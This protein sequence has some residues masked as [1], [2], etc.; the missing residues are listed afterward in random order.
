MSNP[1]TFAVFRKLAKQTPSKMVLLILDGVGGLPMTPGGMTELEA[2]RTPNL[3]ALAAISSLGETVPV[4]QGITP[5]SGPGHLGLFGYDPIEYQV[6]RGALEAVGIDFDLRPTDVAARGNFCTLDAQGNVADRRAGRPSDEVCQRVSALLDGIAVGGDSAQCLVRPVR[7]HRFVL[8]LRG[9]GLSE[10]LDETDPQATGVP[11]LDV[12]PLAP[13]A[14]TTA[15]LFNEFIA[16]AKQRLADQAPTNGLLLRGFAQYPQLPSLG[17]TFGLKPA[18][19]AVY[20]MYRGLAKLAGMKILDAGK[21][22]QDQMTALRAGW[23]AHDFFF[24]HH[25]YTDSRGEDGDFDA[26]V[27]E[28]EKVDAM[29]PDILALKPDVLLVTGDHSTPAKLKSHSWHPVP[30]LLHSNVCRTEQA[31]GFG[32]RQCAHGQLGTVRAVDLLPLMMANAGKFEK[33]GA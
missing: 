4:L 24:I 14:V 11:A 23:E 17:D 31:P 9:E 13:E 29:V 21:N 26:K 8:V 22:L 16:Q 18:A 30:V 5:G 20:P 7:E 2:A 32:E 10:R 1:A 15:A 33:F 19:I 3:D 27:A 28:I 25:K 12:Q 6:G